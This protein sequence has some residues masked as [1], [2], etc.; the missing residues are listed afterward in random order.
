MRKSSLLA[1]LAGVAAVALHSQAMAQTTPQGAE[2]DV[3]TVDE[4]VVTAQKREQ[5]LQDVPIT[6]SVVNGEQLTRQNVNGVEDLTR[7]NPALNSAG[8]PGFGALAIR[9][10]G[11]LSFSRS[12]EGSVGVVVDGVALANTS[13]IP[14]QLFDIA[15][16][17]VLE[18]PQGTL[19]GRNA[20][21]GVLNV[22]TNAPDPTGFDAIGHVDVGSRNN[23]V[24]RG[25]VNLPIGD[26]AALRVSGGYSQDPQVQKNLYDGS[27]LRRETKGGRARFL[28]EPNDRL[29]VNLSADYTR[30][31]G[32]GGVLYIPYAA[33]PTRPFG[34][35][36]AACGVTVGPD[37][38]AG[39]TNS[40]NTQK[41]ESYGVS[42]QVDYDLN[43][44]TLTSI[45]AYR[46]LSSKAFN[47]VDSVPVTRLTQFVDNKADNFSQEFRIASPTGGFFEYVA[48]LYYF[49]SRTDN[50]I[51][52]FG[53][54]LTDLNL[55][56]GCPLPAAVLC[57]MNV[58]QDA[59][60]GTETT[61][62]AAYGQATIN[63]TDRL[64]FILGARLGHEDVRSDSVTT[65]AAGAIG[66]ISPSLPIDATVKDD[67]FSYRV[68]VQYDVTPKSIAYATFTRGYKGPAVN[69]TV[70]SAAVP[71]IVNPEIPNAFEVGVKTNL[72]RNAALNVSAYYT[73]IDDFQAQFFDVSIPAFVFG[74]APE[75]TSKGVAVNL[76]GRAFDGL[77]GSIGLA[78]N[79]ATY[80]KG[81]L[82]SNLANAVVSADGNTLIGSAKWKATA[83][84]EY[85]RRLS[86][87][88]EAYI[89]GDVV[90]QSRRESNAA[91][92]DAVSIEGAAIVGGRVG[93]RWDEGRFGA[94][95]YARNL[96]DE[97]RPAIRLA[98]PTAAQQLD[99][100][101]LS[102]FSGPE[103]HR[104]IGVSLD[105]RF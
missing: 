105:A 37:N 7:T 47:D 30:I 4:I 85:A 44:T 12:S 79:D 94:S 96:F 58:G 54:V 90:Y 68:G 14:P 67:Y 101:A 61:S 65:V 62:Y 10:V 77:T 13:I 26:T 28:W 103:S 88:L 38:D 95:I 80:G 84:G 74:N 18:G 24:A 93:V 50:L 39:C 53:A 69:D 75:L 19:F 29:T 33:D 45:T 102:Q 63:A 70:T 78:Y 91:N 40:G 31:N 35:R 57:T 72:S 104:V 83:S 43:G 15:R 1:L 82:V 60:I 11:N 92:D 17:E 36:L 16:V 89:Q 64:R 76:F 55:I 42:G 87:G 22:V 73:K 71:V 98:T 46:G 25:A 51:S 32:D 86:N 21:A 23:Y 3:T 66:A 27:W 6:I 9:G 2:P 8:P 41:N 48:G 49:H 97:Y 99:P 100:S 56:G 20:S 59:V 52:Q 34:A 5:R 81:Y